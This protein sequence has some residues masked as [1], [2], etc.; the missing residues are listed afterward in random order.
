MPKERQESLSNTEKRRLLSIFEEQ[1]KEKWFKNWTTHMAIPEDLDP[2]SKKKE[3]RE[4]L[5]R[6]LLL[7]TLI[8]QQASF[9]KVREVSVRL[10]EEFENTLLFKPQSLFS[11]IGLKRMKVLLGGWMKIIKIYII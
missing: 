11:L 3:E 2:F 9:E 10:F 1:V 6:Y 5:L 4:K 7:R 8:N